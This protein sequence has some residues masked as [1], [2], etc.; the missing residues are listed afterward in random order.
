M[1]ETGLLEDRPRAAVVVGSA[2]PAKG[3]I[4]QYLTRYDTSMGLDD[5]RF[6]NKTF[7]RHDYHFY[8]RMRLGNGAL[9]KWEEC[10]DSTRTQPVR[11]ESLDNLTRGDYNGYLSPTTARKCKRMLEVWINSINCAA[12]SRLKDR[13]TG[14]IYT[15]FLTLTL[16]HHQVHDDNEIKRHIL[17]PFIQSLQ[18]NLGVTQYF[19]KAEPQENGRIHFHMLIDAFIDTTAVDQFW[20]FHC[21]TLGYVSRYCEESG[22]LFPPACQIVSLAANAAAIPYVIKYLAKAPHRLRS[23]TPKAELGSDYC[24]SKDQFADMGITSLAEQK[25]YKAHVRAELREVRKSYWQPK[26]GKD[27]IE[28]HS[29]YRPIDGRVWGCS[30]AIRA[31]SSPTV[32]VSDRCEMLQEYAKSSRKSRVVVMERALVIGCNVPE[33]VRNFDSGLWQLWRWHHLAS[34]RWLYMNREKP[35]SGNYYDLRSALE[36]CKT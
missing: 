17:M 2:I 26:K 20:G 34:F 23:I 3:D 15:T 24:T 14:Q 19:W 11:Q 33:M 18:R 29:Q 5:V 7:G 9:V 36:E 30:D 28:R 35:P 8:E 25:E 13:I 10:I 1:V 31:L 6:Y 4:E 22:S 32:A 16:P 27:G 21:E 12:S